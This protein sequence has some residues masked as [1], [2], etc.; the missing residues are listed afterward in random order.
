MKSTV[1]RA[2]LAALATGA[3]FIALPFDAFACSSCGCRL[4]VDG[5]SPGL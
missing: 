4:T 5:A 2:A 1:T 3:A